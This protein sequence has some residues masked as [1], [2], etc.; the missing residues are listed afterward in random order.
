MKSIEETISEIGMTE[1]GVKCNFSFNEVKLIAIRYATEYAKE[2]LKEAYISINA[3]D[4]Y[5]KAWGN[6]KRSIESEDNLPN[7]E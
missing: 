5:E 4:V 2:A 6:L 7:H 1:D 3:N